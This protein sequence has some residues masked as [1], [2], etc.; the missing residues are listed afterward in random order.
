MFRSHLHRP[1]TVVPAQDALTWLAEQ[2]QDEYEPDWTTS[3]WTALGA[4]GAASVILTGAVLLGLWVLPTVLVI[5]RGL[6]RLV[7]AG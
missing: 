7:A 5:L 6:V 3:R 4:L 2:D 1:D